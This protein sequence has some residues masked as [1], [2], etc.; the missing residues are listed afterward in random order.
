[1]H[2]FAGK[3]DESVVKWMFAFQLFGEQSLNYIY[4]RMDSGDLEPL[5]STIYKHNLK[6]IDYKL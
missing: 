1:M 5:Q 4:E 2:C 3:N 6:I